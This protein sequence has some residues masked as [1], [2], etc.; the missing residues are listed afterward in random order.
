MQF[1]RL[2]WGEHPIERGC[3]N[4][5]CFMEKSHRK[6]DFFKSLQNRSVALLYISDEIR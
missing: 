1:F 2:Q 3:Q 6:P 4:R 5:Q